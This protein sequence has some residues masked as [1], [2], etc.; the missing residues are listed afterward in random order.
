MKLLTL[1]LAASLYAADPPAEAPKPP[2]A[3]VNNCTG[4]QIHGQPP[5]TDAECQLMNNA[6]DTAKQ[7]ADAKAEIAALR[8]HIA[9]YQAWTQKAF[10]TLEGQRSSAV[11]S[12]L[13]QPPQVPAPHAT[14]K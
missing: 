6:A 9:E 4:S 5:P 13:G 1:F 3:Y 10:T 7:L 2:T 12:C 8:Q 14:A 11:N